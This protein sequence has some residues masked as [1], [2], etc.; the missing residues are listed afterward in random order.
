MS[1]TYYDT[2]Y[3]PSLWNGGGGPVTDGR[4]SASP[5]DTFTEPAITAENPANAALL[6]PLGF[7]ADP[8]TDWT[9]G[10]SMTVTTFA[11]N[12][13]GSAWAAGASAVVAET[14]VQ[15]PVVPQEAS[16]A[17]GGTETAQDW[18]EPPTGP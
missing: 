12:W 10:Q 8:P 16:E 3:P 13:T 4:D 14:A 17:S 9:V 1:S 18:P 2:S 15:A 7:V 5:G 11:F 6:G